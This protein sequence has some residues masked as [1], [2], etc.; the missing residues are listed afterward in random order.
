MYGQ[1][2]TKIS[3]KNIPASKECYC[4]VYVIQ[5][6]FFSSS[7]LII[8]W[9]L[10]SK[11]GIKLNCDSKFLKCIADFNQLLKKFYFIKS[12]MHETIFL[13]LYT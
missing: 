1:S 9:S 10:N 4:L 3:L 6:T 13:V 7:T 5:R 2:Y 12:Q 8:G 11:W